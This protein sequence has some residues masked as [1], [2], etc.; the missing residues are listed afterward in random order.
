MAKTVIL[1]KKIDTTN[2]DLVEQR[3]HNE[4]DGYKG[5]VI[6]DCD[7]LEYISSAGL[8]IILKIKKESIFQLVCSLEI[9]FG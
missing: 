9:M 5:D 1:Y 4:L 6:I 2:I 3:L 7:E 8:R